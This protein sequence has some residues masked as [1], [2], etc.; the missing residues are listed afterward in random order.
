[1]VRRNPAGQNS[2]VLSHHFTQCFRS[3]RSRPRPNLRFRTTSKPSRYTESAAHTVSAGGIAAAAASP[4]FSNQ[5]DAAGRCPTLRPDARLATRDASRVSASRIGSR[6]FSIQ[7]GRTCRATGA[8][9]HR[10]APTR[11]RL[12]PNSGLKSITIRAQPAPHGEGQ[13]QRRQVANTNAFCALDRGWPASSR[14]VTA[15]AAC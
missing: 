2:A 5:R 4:R 13:W 1:M 14:V 8:D 7:S 12:R 9:L 3:F 10:H 6:W 15:L 11:R